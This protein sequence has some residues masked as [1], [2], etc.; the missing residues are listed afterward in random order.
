MSGGWW[1]PVEV[2]GLKPHRRQVRRRSRR[3]VETASSDCGEAGR[4]SGRE[5]SGTEGGLFCFNGNDP[6][7]KA[8]GEAP[9]EGDDTSAAGAKEGVLG[10]GGREKGSRAREKMGV[11]IWECGL[12]GDPL[13]FSVQLSSVSLV[14]KYHFLLCPEW[15]VLFLL[16]SF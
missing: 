11:L 12:E 4:G 6:S 13:W 3:Q 16:S 8:D 1:R 15:S 7:L 10:K 14:K 2:Q 9:P 5:V